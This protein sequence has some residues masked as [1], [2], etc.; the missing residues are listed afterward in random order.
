MMDRRAATDAARSRNRVVAPRVKGVATQQP[1]HRK[2]R[3]LRR[4]VTLDRFHRVRRTGGQEAARRRKNGRN[5]QPVEPDRAQAP[6]RDRAPRP[7]A[8][9]AFRDHGTA[10]S[11]VASRAA[12]ASVNA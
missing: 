3:A 11:H 4:P 1:P 12:T 6:A 10:R 2:P 8:F 7:T 5:D 9:D